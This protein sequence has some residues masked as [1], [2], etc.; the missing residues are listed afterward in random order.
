[1]KNVPWEQIEPNE[2]SDWVNQRASNFNDYIL[3]GDKKDKT[4]NLIFSTYS[5][6]IKT[7]RDPWVYG[8]SKNKI[9]QKLTRL[10]NFYNSEVKRYEDAKNML[11]AKQDLIIEDFIS[12]DATKISWSRALRSDIKKGKYIH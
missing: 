4:E 5:M 12:L 3:I 10:L 7:N 2:F 6:G 11:S 1:M 9:E 8:F